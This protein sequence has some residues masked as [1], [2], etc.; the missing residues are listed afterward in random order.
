ME[1]TYL[2]KYFS[3]LNLK[4]NQV[5]HFYIIL[6]IH[7]LVSLHISLYIMKMNSLYNYILYTYNVKKLKYILN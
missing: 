5:L 3:S 6:F 4:Y 1:Y 2:I 7:N